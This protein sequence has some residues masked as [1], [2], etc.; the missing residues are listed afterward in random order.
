[1]IRGMF[2]GQQAGRPVEDVLG[3]VQVG[4][5]GTDSVRVLAEPGVGLGHHGAQVGGGLDAARAPP[6]Q[7]PGV[8]AAAASARAWRTRS[9]S[10]SVAGRAATSSSNRSPTRGAARWAPRCMPRYTSSCSTCRA[11]APSAW[12]QVQVA[13]TVRRIAVSSVQCRSASL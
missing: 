13:A 12:S 9:G 4:Q 5:A 1:M 3:L 2:S 10:A 6:A 11:S 8:P 7:V